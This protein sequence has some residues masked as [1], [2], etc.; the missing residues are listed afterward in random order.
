M[1]YKNRQLRDSH[2][3]LLLVMTKEWKHYF[4]V[5]VIVHFTDINKIEHNNVM[6][7]RPMETIK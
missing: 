3:A 4:F 7:Y 6:S 5:R 2:V 1:A